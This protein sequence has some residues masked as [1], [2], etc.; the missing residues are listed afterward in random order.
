MAIAEPPRAIP[1][2]VGTSVKRKEDPR[3]ITGNGQY[4]DDIKLP[5]MAHVAIL[6][7]LRKIGAVKKGAAFHKTVELPADAA[8]DRVIVFVQDSDMGRI[9]GAALLEK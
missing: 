8:S 7:S 4:L 5:G 6:R 3:L 9:S 2:L 1:K